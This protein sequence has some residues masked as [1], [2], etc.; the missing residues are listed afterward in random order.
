[1]I[2]KRSPSVAVV[3]P[4]FNEKKG[5][6][7]FVSELLE[8][9]GSLP[10]VGKTVLVLVD[11]GSSDGTSELLDALVEEQPGVMTVLHLSLLTWIPTSRMTHRLF[12]P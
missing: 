4:V 7:T 11:D 5:I 8:V 10:E 3:A 12:P 1:M 2:R 9:L 6:E